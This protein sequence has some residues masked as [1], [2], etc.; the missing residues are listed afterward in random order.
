MK[1]VN[2]YTASVPYHGRIWDLKSQEF[3]NYLISTAQEKRCLYK[4]EYLYDNDAYHI[5]SYIDYS[6]HDEGPKMAEIQWAE[7]DKSFDLDEIIND[8]HFLKNSTDKYDDIIP[9]SLFD[10]LSYMQD[11]EYYSAYEYT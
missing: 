2:F 4:V 1:K 11:S 5:E 8:L 7:I 9:D 3:R 10:F 6:K